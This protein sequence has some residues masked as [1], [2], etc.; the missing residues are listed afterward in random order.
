ME[1]TGARWTNH[2]ALRTDELVW[3]ES[4]RW[5]DGELWVSDTQRSQLVVIGAET[6]AVHALGSAVNG[7]AFLPSGDLV[8][9]RMHDARLDRFD[10]ARWEPYADLGDLVSGRLGDLI[11]LADGTVYVD[12]VVSPDAPGRLLKVDVDGRAT[13]AADELV[14]P[15]GLAVVDDGRTLVVAETFA[16]RLTAFPIGADGGLGARR[17]F[18]DLREHLGA[19]YRPD[20]IWACRDGSVWVATTTGEEVVRVRDG[21]VVER[22]AVGEFAIACCLDDDER[23]LFV[24]VASSLDAG[25]SVIDAAYAQRTRAR[26]LRLRRAGS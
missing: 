9:A 2:G 12:E 5:R 6:T 1:P 7:T 26:V 18:I 19:E 21:R 15:N 25:V 16:C 17:G 24:T 13:V 22:I 4:P 10:G 20:G 3:A 8:A 23:E 11:A 14:F